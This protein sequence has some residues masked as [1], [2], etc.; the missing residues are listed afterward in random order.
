[1]NDEFRVAT[2]D[3]SLQDITPT[4]VHI[5][6]HGQFATDPSQ[7]YLLTADKDS[8]QA[9]SLNTLEQIVRPMQ[10]QNH[11][12]ELL[13]LSA[14]QTAIG[15]DRAAL[16][17]AGVAIKAGARSALASLWL[18][19]D[20]ASATIMHDFYAALLLPAKHADGPTYRS[21]A[22]ALRIAQVKQI[23]H[24]ILGHPYYWSAFMMIGNWR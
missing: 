4:I 23:K 8:G 1:M 9:L 7:T 22:Q 3:R 11:P 14:C 10:F 13:T 12:V 6:S 15:D 2:F 16:G 21:K 24:P 5:A 19:N 17:L 20:E 18:V